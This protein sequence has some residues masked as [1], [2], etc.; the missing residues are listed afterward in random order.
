MFPM[1][2]QKKYC[3]IFVKDWKYVQQS[4]THILFRTC[5]TIFFLLEAACL[6]FIFE[7]LRIEASSAMTIF[8]CFESTYDRP[9]WAVNP[10]SV[11]LPPYYSPSSAP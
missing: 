6:P 8:T 11:F 5:F 10:R 4:Y 2:Q 9:V 3:T 1:L 7:T